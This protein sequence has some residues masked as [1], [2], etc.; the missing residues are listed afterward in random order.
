[1]SINAYERLSGKLELYT[2]LEEGLEDVKAGRGEPAEQFFAGLME[3]LERNERKGTA[4]CGPLK[5]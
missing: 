1:M 2:L 4:G 3:E 5:E